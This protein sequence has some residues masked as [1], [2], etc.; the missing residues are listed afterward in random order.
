MRPVQPLPSSGSV[1]EA[2]RTA[3]PWLSPAMRRIADVVLNDPD[4]AARRTSSEI[5][6]RAG[7]SPATVTRFCAAV[8][9]ESFQGLVHRLARET[10]RKDADTWSGVE[11]SVDIDIAGDTHSTAMSVAAA[12]IRGIRLSAEHLDIA[13][14]TQ[15]AERIAAADRID[16]YGA[17]GSGSVAQETSQRLFRIG[18]PIRSWNDIHGAATSACLLGPQDVAIAISDSGTTKETHEALELAQRAGATGIAVTSDPRSPIAR[19]ADIPLTT[20]LGVGD[21]AR[22]R[23]L[24]SRHAQLFVIDCLYV[25]VAQLTERRARLAVERTDLVGDLHTVPPHAPRA[26]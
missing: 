18:V 25:L 13:L 24:T 9:V 19:L 7:V 26:R 15:A 4:D 8:G 6:A 10:G 21:S 12:A 16:V 17:G 2:I 11:M 22:T 1:H 3:R 14:L 23:T 5:A 20:S